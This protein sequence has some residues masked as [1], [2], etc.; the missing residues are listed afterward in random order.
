MGLGLRI[1]LSVMM[2]LQYFVFGVWLPTLAQHLGENDLKLSVIHI[3]WIFSVYGLGS[4]FGPFVI[5]QLADRYFAT[6]KVMALAHFVGG[7]LLVLAAYATTFWP[8]FILLL[9]YCNLFM[10][11]MGLSNSITFRSLGD[12]NQA[13][14]PGVRVWGTVGWI[15][16]GLLFPMY[17]D[18]NK[19]GFYQQI[20]D[21]V[22]QHSAYE[23]LLKTWQA[24]VVPLLKPVFAIPWIGEPQFRD[25]LR[26]PGVVSIVYAIYCL[27]LPHTP[28]SPAKDTD[29]IDKKSAVLE[30]LELMKYR[31][32]AVLVVITGLIGI[33][34]AYYFACENTFLESIGI[35]ATDAGAYMTFGQF[36][37]ALVMLFVPLAVAKLGVKNTMLIGAGA[38]A[39]R[40]GLSAYGQPKWLMI[41]TIGLHGF[42]FGFYFVVAQMYV[43][44]AASNDIKASAQNLLI[45][46]IYGLGTVV[47][48]VLT[49]VVRDFYKVK[50]PDG[51]FKDD[52][53]GIWF[54][55]FILTIICMIAFALLFREQEIGS[56][57]E[58]EKPSL[59]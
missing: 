59:A 54:G 8:I 56:K 24:S 17:M 41:A 28:P 1:R 44:K 3:G 6:E 21:A 13:S 9:L 12:N 50:Q 14:F 55:P 37:E 53:T 7:I 49:G 38:W 29:P 36:G 40:F 35:P 26:L 39:L 27:T 15:A 48:S 51:S 22:G 31:S 42:A 23:S 2:F 57:V 58:E 18:Y 46:V 25:C 47:G 4:I 34:L 5:G 10:P 20:L 45:F 11:T 30:C 33:M 43:D 19:L 32:F 16:A 52:W